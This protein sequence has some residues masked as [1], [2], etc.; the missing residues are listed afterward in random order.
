MPARNNTF[1]LLFLLLAYWV[2]SLSNLTVVPRVYEDEPWQASTGYKLATEGVFGSDM[3]AGFYNMDKRYYGYLPLHPILLAVSFRLFGLGLFQARFESV[4]LGLVALALTYALGRRLFRSDAVGVLAVFFLLCAR[5]AGVTP[6]QVSGVLFLDIPRIARYDMV[7]PVFGLAALH[8]FLSARPRDAPWGFA[9]CGALAGL[10][11]LGHLYGVFWLP[12]LLVLT[13]WDRASLSKL[14]TFP[15]GPRRVTDPPGAGGEPDAV[16]QGAASKPSFVPGER[17]TT[18]LLLQFR[19][20][21]FP[22]LLGFTAVWLPYLVYVATDLT[23]FA[24]QGRIY[25]DEGRFSLSSPRWYVDN[26]LAER[27]RYGP[28]LEGGWRGLL[29]PGFWAA[30]AGLPIAT[31]ALARRALSGGDFA[32]RALLV[33]AVVIAALFALLIRLKLANYL[34]TLVPL[35]ALIAAWGTVRF[36]QRLERSRWWG[37]AALAALL[38][39]VGL[40]GIGRAAVLQASA[41]VTTPYHDYIARVRA[42][43]L[44]GKSVGAPPPRVVGLHTF[45]FGLTDMDYRSIWVPLRQTDPRLLSNPLTFDAALEQI[46]PDVF[47]LDSRVG[48]YLDSVATPGVPGHEL[49]T[50]FEAWKARHDVRLAG[51]VEDATYG[52]M[53]IYRVEDERSAMSDE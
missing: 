50:Q 25:A 13:L 17:R 15:M 52:T 47:L 36:W 51:R 31:L 46:A 43:I 7:V 35:G 23:D 1:V 26:L 24:V 45:W 10:A 3:F 38:V 2:V 42:H 29:R 21:A 22:L 14:N 44:E 18:L 40:E 33:P 49:Y 20:R 37:R 48:A 12:A 27:H 30:V 41:A 53:E 16:L 5:T 9:S 28:G 8:A 19:R 32:A 6:S 34:A 11:G 39:A 4:V